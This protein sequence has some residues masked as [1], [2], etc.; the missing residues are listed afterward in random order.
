[1]QKNYSTFEKNIHTYC[2]N[3]ELENVLFPAFVNLW[4]E[5]FPIEKK[6]LVI[7]T[8][9]IINN[10]LKK[11]ILQRVFQGYDIDCE[12][13]RKDEFGEYVEIPYKD[14]FEDGYGLFKVMPHE[15]LVK[16]SDVIKRKMKLLGRTCN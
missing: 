12:V 3:N 6:D 13:F 1:M 16:Y 11:G 14:C 7:V 15:D 10:L 9:N 5:D 8:S 4:D 2:D